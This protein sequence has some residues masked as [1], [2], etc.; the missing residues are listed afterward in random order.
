M[1]QDIRIPE[2]QHAKPDFRKAVSPPVIILPGGGIVVLSPV[3]LDD[4]SVLKADKIDNVSLDR[5]LAGELEPRELSAPQDPPEF[6][7]RV[8]AF[9]AHSAREPRKTPIVIS[10]PRH[11][12]IFPILL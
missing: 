9:R 8:G 5:I 6:S 12:C 2:A 11:Q 4:Q 7:L 1:L 3:T 10:P